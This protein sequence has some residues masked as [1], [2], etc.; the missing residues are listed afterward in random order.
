MKKKGQLVKRGTLD[1]DGDLE[2]WDDGSS[3]P[4]EERISNSVASDEDAK[5]KL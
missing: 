5:P 4:R 1:L 3:T 2:L